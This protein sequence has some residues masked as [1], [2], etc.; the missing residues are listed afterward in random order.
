MMKRGVGRC[1]GLLVLGLVWACG[2]APTPDDRGYTKAPLEEPGLR[3]QPEVPTDMARH[4]EPKLPD[5]PLE[6][7]P[8]SAG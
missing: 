8:D 7:P 1:M 2:D 5:P 4:G 3:V 6:P